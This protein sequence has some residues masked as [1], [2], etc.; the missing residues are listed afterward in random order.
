MASTK[1]ATDEEVWQRPEAAAA[2]DF[3]MSF[4]QGYDALR[5][6][7]G[8]HLGGGQKQRVAIAAL[9]CSTPG[10]DLG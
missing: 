4:P 1:H 5:G 7:T 3:I 8:R 2:H 9:S 6:G 10:F